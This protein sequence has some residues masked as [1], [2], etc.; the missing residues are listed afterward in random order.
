MTIG[1]LQ[2]SLASF[3]AERDWE[4]FHTPKNLAMALTGECGEL[5][6]IFQWLTPDESTTVMDDPVRAA[7]VREEMADVFA[8]L[9]R[10][11]DVLELDLERAL[12]DK[13]EVNR[14]KYPA[15]L[16]RG[17]ADKYTQLGG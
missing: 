5:V 17:R 7:R 6:E 8:Y 9:L 12:A 11:A 13:I 15:H 16:A 14:G 3:A 4:Q 1:S 10:M 2:Q